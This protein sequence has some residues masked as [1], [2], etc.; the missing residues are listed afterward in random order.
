VK[1]T[2]KV[3]AIKKAQVDQY[4]LL[5]NTVEDGYD[6]F[7][8][9]FGPKPE[10]LD[11]RHVMSMSAADASVE[12]GD[13]AIRAAGYAQSMIGVICKLLN[14][15][16]DVMLGPPE[17]WKDWG[18]TTKEN[19]SPIYV[20]EDGAGNRTTYPASSSYMVTK[21]YLLLQLFGRLSNHFGGTISA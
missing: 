12:Y 7:G 9:L 17:N 8:D 14:L 18:F 16:V 10:L 1:S 6:R 20:I 11:L 3:Q 13:A 21:R 4:S 5:V 15:K 2:I 19:W